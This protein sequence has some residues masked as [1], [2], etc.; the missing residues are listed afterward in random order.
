MGN[1]WL[2][3]CIPR[4]I[5]FVACIHQGHDTWFIAWV[6]L[7]L[8]HVFFLTLDLLNLACIPHEINDIWFIKW[9]T[10][11]LL[12]AL[13]LTFGMHFRRPVTSR[14]SVSELYQLIVPDTLFWKKV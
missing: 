11:S 5:W 14:L 1:T 12:H 10:L 8:L 3:A 7:G 4:Y 9:V 6:T 2:A 13:L